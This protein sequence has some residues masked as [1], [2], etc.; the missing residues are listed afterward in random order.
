MGSK[1]LIRFILVCCSIPVCDLSQL[2][3]LPTSA[4]GFEEG[5]HVGESPILHPARQYREPIVC[6]TGCPLVPAIPGQL[7]LIGVGSPVVPAS[8]AEPPGY[9]PPLE[10]R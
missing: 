10:K 7:P 2:V 6:D 5:H 8:F 1:T 9:P 4:D 3:L